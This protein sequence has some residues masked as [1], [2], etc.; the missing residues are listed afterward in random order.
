MLRIQRIQ[1]KQAGGVFARQVLFGLMVATPAPRWGVWWWATKLGTKGC[2]LSSRQLYKSSLGVDLGYKMRRRTDMNEITRSKYHQN[3]EKEYFFNKYVIIDRLI[4][5]L[6]EARGK[7][8]AAE[9]QSGKDFFRLKGHLSV[10]K[11][12]VTVWFFSFSFQ[13]VENRQSLGARVS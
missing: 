1:I 5:P 8:I 11:T 2:R 12:R 6:R 3:D 4:N 13:T 10:E 9:S 7:E